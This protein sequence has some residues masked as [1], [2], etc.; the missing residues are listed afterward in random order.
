MYFRLKD[1]LKN[2]K[3]KILHGASNCVDLLLSRSLG[4]YTKVEQQN[5][6]GTG[7]KICGNHVN[8]LLKDWSLLNYHHFLTEWKTSKKAHIKKCSFP[9]DILPNV[10]TV[11]VTLVS[12][13][14]P[15]LQ[16][17]QAKFILQSQGIL[18][19]PGLRK[20]IFLNSIN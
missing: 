18:L 9:H 13:Q 16:K 14:L 20:F 17:G 10:H 19:H 6:I 2:Y 1:L 7:Y 12:N 8:E 3:S 15:E 11:D 4:I 5:L